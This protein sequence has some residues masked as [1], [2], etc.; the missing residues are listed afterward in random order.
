MPIPREG[1]S[2]RMG[3]THSVEARL[4]AGWR[5][6]TGQPPAYALYDPIETEDERRQRLV[7]AVLDEDLQNDHRLI[8]A[9]QEAQLGPGSPHTNPVGVTVQQETQ[10]GPADSNVGTVEAA[11]SSTELEQAIG[12][13]TM[14]ASQ[15][16]KSL[17]R[18]LIR[19]MTT[20][21]NVGKPQNNPGPELGRDTLASIL[22]DIGDHLVQQGQGVDIIA[23]GDLVNF[24]RKPAVH[25][26]Y[27]L[28]Q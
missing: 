13:V 6:A 28:V 12:A 24:H 19:E 10:P 21:T 3:L 20:N 1:L 4:R 7:Q 14:N 9:R 5:R 11:H 26:R 27:R 25:C 23:V 18:G 16:Q 22:R 2:I 8:A 17:F 15:R